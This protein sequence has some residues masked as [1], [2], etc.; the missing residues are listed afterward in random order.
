M[1]TGPVG[2]V[3]VLFYWPE[4]V[5]GNFYW[6]GA[7]GSPLASS[8]AGICFGKYIRRWVMFSPVSQRFLRVAHII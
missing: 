7:I 4:A 6:P 2:P 1:F 3:K 8:P 5:F